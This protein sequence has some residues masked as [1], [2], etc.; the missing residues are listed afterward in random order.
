MLKY[1]RAFH[2]AFSDIPFVNYT[3][4]ERSCGV[5]GFSLAASVERVRTRARMCWT[6]DAKP[7]RYTVYASNCDQASDG[8]CFVVKC[9][10]R[11]EGNRKLPIIFSLCKF[12]FS[13]FTLYY[14]YTFLSFY[15]YTS[16]GITK[17]IF[18]YSSFPLLITLLK[19]DNRK[20]KSKGRMWEEDMY[21][22]VIEWC[23]LSTE[24]E[25]ISLFCT[26]FLFS[27]LF[28][29]HAYSIPVFLKC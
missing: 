1:F 4:C 7:C 6:S 17:K 29:S 10:W 28:F 12:C 9:F 3:S 21:V 16:C 15:W 18:T 22:N 27:Y 2:A 25:N 14:S 8:F 13:P 19:K 20:K 5:G 24:F 23:K 26:T 11:N